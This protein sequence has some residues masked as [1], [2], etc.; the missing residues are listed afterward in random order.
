MFAGLLSRYYL[1]TSRELQRLESICR[2]SVYSHISET[3]DELDTI[4]TR[5]KE[6]DFVARFHRVSFFDVTPSLYLLG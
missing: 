3:L 1:K 6:G 4:R 5:K 2:S